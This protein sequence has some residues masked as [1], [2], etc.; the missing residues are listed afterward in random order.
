MKPPK[1]TRYKHGDVHESGR[2]F[3]A[4]M[5]TKNGWS[6]KTYQ[7]TSVFEVQLKLMLHSAKQRAI[8]ERLPFDLD[9]PYLR[10]IAV[11][12][13]P[14]FGFTLSWGELGKG[15]SNSH[16]AP[17]LDKVKP[18][19]GYVKGNVF[20][21]SKLANLIK[22][23]VGYAELYK[24]ADWLHDTIKEV[25]KNVRPEQLTSIPT[26][27]YKTRSDKGKSRP[28]PA[29]RLRQDGDDF[30]HHSGAIRRLDIDH[31]AQ[32]SS[33]DRMGRGGQ[34]VESPQASFNFESYGVSCPAVEEFIR[35]GGHLPDKS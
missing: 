24:V 21:I 28:V 23:D 33:R 13:C 7:E 25:E 15:H 3:M 12:I 29:A 26:R 30:N 32:A 2:V 1:P 6:E 19:W 22:Q 31:S 34:E 18:E 27:T 5:W 9:L 35:G 4:Y 14:V 11:S 16:K 8:K 20:I 10:S 17:S